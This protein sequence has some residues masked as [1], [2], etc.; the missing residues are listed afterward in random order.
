MPGTTGIDLLREVQQRWPDTIRIVL[1]GYSEVKAIIAAINQGAIYKFITKP[2]NDEELKLNVRRAIEQY[3]LEAENRRMA[4][5]I[6]AQNERLVELNR[7]LDERA[8]DAT[9]GLTITQD[10]LDAIEAGMVI[11][12]ET[13]LVVSANRKALEILRSRRDELIGIPARETLP[14]ELREAASI[15]TE[16][17]G[18]GRIHLA[19]HWL[20]W[21]ACPAVRGE[22]R[23]GRIVTLWEE[24]G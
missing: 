23:R 2:W 3:D 24:I 18:S 4:E 11:V 17:S 8:E 21:R 20:Q 6:A 10:L 22:S 19:G 1:S 9:A 12:D 15:D 5:E 14:E 13:G 16:S 7:Y